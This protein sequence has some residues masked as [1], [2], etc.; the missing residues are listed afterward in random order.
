ME[1]ADTIIA[2]GATYLGYNS[3]SLDMELISNNHEDAFVFYFSEHARLEVDTWEG[4][5]Q[6]L[7]DLLNRRKGNSLFM[8][9]D[10]DFNDMTLEKSYITHY[11]NCKPIVKDL[12][13]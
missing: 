1:F 7:F 13:E 5:L 8:V 4:N 3:E 11:R 6:L 12:L 10:C 2:K 9:V